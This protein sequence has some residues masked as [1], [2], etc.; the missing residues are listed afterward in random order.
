M[1]DD[2]TALTD[3]PNRADH[4]L[5]GPLP[6]RLA[7]RGPRYKET[8]PDPYA[9]TAPPVAEPWNAVTAALFVAIVLGWVGRLRGRFRD[10]PFLSCCLPILLAGGIGGTLYHAYRSRLAYFL[11]DVIPIQLLGL[12]A[13]IYL[14]TRL[15]RGAKLWKVLAIALGLLV[16]FAAVNEGL[17]RLLDLPIRNLRVNLNYA[18][19]ALLILIPLGVVLV[20]TGFRHVGWVAGGLASFAIAWFFRLIDGTPYDTLPM[21]THWLWHTF[22]AITTQAVMEYFYRVEGDSKGERPPVATGGL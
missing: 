17:F 6:D 2:P 19:L 9:A 12:A 7:D 15:V 21:G 8:P 1:R 4:F 3:D 18:A 5:V 11:L 10:Y 22:G 20:R 14:T 16:V 13:S